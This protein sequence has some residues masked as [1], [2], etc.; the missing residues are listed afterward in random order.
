MLSL[1]IT[2]GVQTTRLLFSRFPVRI[3]RE[4]PSDCILDFPFVSKCHARL[5]LNDGALVLHDEGS[6][7]GIF[8]RAGRERVGAGDGVPLAGVGG[9]FQIGTLRFQAVVLMDGVRGV[10]QGGT[11]TLDHGGDLAAFR[12]PW[13]R[14]AGTDA[15]PYGA[16]EPGGV[17][18]SRAPY[19]SSLTD[20]APTRRQLELSL[21]TYRRARGELQDAIR[22]A[23]ATHDT[24][25]VVTLLADIA[26]DC[27][28]LVLPVEVR[29][30]VARHGA[31]E[32]GER[33]LPSSQREGDAELALRGLRELAAWAAPH[34]P[35]LAGTEGIVAFLHRLAG[36]FRGLVEAFAALRVGSRPRMTADA[37]GP[38]RVVDSAAALL[39]WTRPGNDARSLLE[40]ELVAVVRDHALGQAAKQVFA[41]LSPQVIEDELPHARRAGSVGV[42]F[43]PFRWRAL[44]R[45]YVARFAELA[46]DEHDSAPPS[47]GPTLA[48][49]YSPPAV[50]P[51][52]TQVPSSGPR[53]IRGPSER[54][55]AVAGARG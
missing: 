19:P 26:G 16:T 49:L 53:A 28:E 21:R 18:I 50:E 6:R 32:S 2:N 10:E 52:E 41:A 4:A 22:R 12:P 36:T 42:G 5:E 17:E 14:V 27:P 35:M 23:I 29:E 3:G 1:R 7:N 51:Q 55:N 25:E 47:F 46:V 8:V 31:P 44:W 45:L 34:A 33:P 37:S 20:L 48:R 9:E 40:H 24:T 54:F 38:P 11:G 30:M 39:D 13:V 43:G 15:D